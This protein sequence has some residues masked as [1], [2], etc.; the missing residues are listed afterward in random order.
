MPILLIGL[1]C[2]E[3][4]Y[5]NSHM[6]IDG[7]RVNIEPN[8]LI[9]DFEN[10]MIDEL[11]PS[12][13]LDFQIGGEGDGLN[14][15]HLRITGPTKDSNFEIGE[16]SISSSCDGAINFVSLDKAVG[17]HYPKCQT[18]AFPSGWTYAPCILYDYARFYF[19]KDGF[20]NDLDGVGT[21]KITSLDQINKRI[22]MSFDFDIEVR[23]DNMS[24]PSA[25]R[26][27]KRVSGKYKGSYR[28]NWLPDKLHIPWRVHPRNPEP[29]P[30]SCSLEVAVSLVYKPV[31]ASIE[32]HVNGVDS[33]T[34]VGAI[35]MFDDRAISCF[36]NTILLEKC[37]FIISKYNDI[38]PEV[39]RNEFISV[40]KTID[41]GSL[42]SNKLV[43]KYQLRD[44]M[45]NQAYTIRLIA[46]YS[47]K[48]PNIDTWTAA[49]DI[50]SVF[51]IRNQAYLCINDNQSQH[52][53]K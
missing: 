25:T 33:T 38:G 31:K 29:K 28:D 39:S 44:L 48:N 21:L 11:C 16:Y 47:L 14:R 12:K 37:V 2:Q 53:C 34:A 10:Y 7:E 18:P 41:F 50:T 20:F 43:F 1:S 46:T 17:Q 23:H 9:I 49:T 5:E 22:N 24:N 6:V 52:D 3:D 8:S 35:E 19:Q 4:E 36:A 32:L 15:W 42:P 27:K 13:Y 26:S 40:P 30:D 45:L 51:T